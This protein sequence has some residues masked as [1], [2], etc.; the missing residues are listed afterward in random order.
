VQGNPCRVVRIGKLYKFQRIWNKQMFLQD[1]RDCCCTRQWDE[2]SATEAK[3]EPLSC[4]LA[5]P[6]SKIWSLG[7]V[8]RTKTCSDSFI[9]RTEH[10]T[11]MDIFVAQ[12][13]CE[14]CAAEAQECTQAIDATKRRTEAG[15]D[16]E[17][18]WTGRKWK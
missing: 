9:S 12:L 4:D 18:F 1:S 13:H 14:D 17:F 15:L 7:G 3:I 11:E 8:S 16:G 5:I 2:T 6:L 10:V